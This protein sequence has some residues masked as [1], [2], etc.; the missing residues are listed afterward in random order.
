MNPQHRPAVFLDRDG[1]IIQQVHHL[2][3]PDEVS[4]IP[5]AASAIQHLSEA[6]YICVVVTNQSVLGRGLLTVE[7]LKEIHDRMCR[8][9]AEQGTAVDAIYFCPIAP[10]GTD[11]DLIEH[12]DRKPGPGMLLKAA[13]E[14]RLDLSSSWMVG[15]MVSDVL[16]GVNA[17]CQ[18]SILVRTGHGGAADDSAA[19]HVVENLSQAAELII[20][21]KISEENRV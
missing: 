8:L 20:H 19:T 17:G 9:L 16:A 13:T 2:A 11:R 21:H 18:G 15:D 6:G 10:S 4:L 14:H 1:T 12:P 3:N 5:G 7:G